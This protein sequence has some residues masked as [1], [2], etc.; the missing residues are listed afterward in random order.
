MKFTIIDAEQ[1]SEAWH[2]ARAGRV[3]GSKADCLL[4]KGRGGAESTQRRDYRIQLACERLTGKPQEAGYINA[5]MQRGIDMEPAH[6][7][8]YE[9]RT[10][11]IVRCTGFLRCDDLPVGCSLDGDIGDFAGLWEGKAPKTATHVG[12]LRDPST[13]L[14]DYRA[15]VTHNLWMVPQ[16]QWLD[17]S[18]FDD[19]LPAPLQLVVVRVMR[20]QVDIAGYEKE[21]HRFLA[22]VSI[23]VRE[24]NDLIK[25]KEAA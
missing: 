16:A 2:A 13:L 15:Q 7:A 9:A 23:E 3:T 14:A 22:E 8:Q 11:D 1:R 4:A 25:L 24:L 5:E 19:R 6:L 21:V 17:L 20:D 12:Y 18:S 10:G